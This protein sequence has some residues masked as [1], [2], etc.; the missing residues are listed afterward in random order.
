MHIDISKILRNNIRE[1]IPYSSARREFNGTDGIFLNANE[2]SFGSPLPEKYNRYPDPLQIEL[3]RKISSMK[4]ISSQ[5]IFLGN[6]SDEAI[7]L[8]FRCFC[9]PG[10]DTV[11]ICPPTYGM[12]EVCAKINDVAVNIV[13]LTSAFQLDVEGI[14]NKCDRN[15]KL[16]FICSPNNP[17]GNTFDR[18]GILSVIRHFNGIVVIDEAYIEYSDQPSFTNELSQHNNI[19]VLQTFSKAWG[20]AGLRIGMA[21]ASE[22]IIDEL[23]KVKPPY[24]ISTVS[25]ELALSA[26]ENSQKI[27]SWMSQTIEERKMLVVELEQLAF[28]VEIYPSEANFLLVKVGNAERIYR[29]LLTEN[30]I[31]RNRNTISQCEGCLRIT[32]GTPEENRNLITSLKNYMP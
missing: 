15:S 11:I 25:Q 27:R 3:K 19:V 10:K 8:L 31:V 1:L 18:N 24:N 12:Y 7:D 20:L 2:N 14:K 28:V 16:I 23:N 5:N 6:G 22:Q 17:S 32:I 29:Y 4:G 26:L 13:P 21:F 9:E 30:I